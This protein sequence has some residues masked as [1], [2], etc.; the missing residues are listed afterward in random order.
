MR[1]SARHPNPRSYAYDDLYADYH[2]ISSEL[3][4]D[5]PIGPPPRRTGG[6]AKV[7]AVFVLL[8][9]GGTWAAFG[10]P[11][12]WPV[13][14]WADWL[15]SQT[16]TAAPEADPKPP[17]PA[18]PIKPAAAIPGPAPEP[19][20]GAAPAPKELSPPPRTVPLTT[21]ALPPPAVGKA[22]AEPLP[23]PTV[24]PGDPY[25]VRAVAVGLH[26]GLSRVLLARL[27]AADYRNAGIAIKTALAETPDTAVLVWP[28]KRAPDLALFKVRFVPG[29][30][31][32]CRRYVVTITKD[33]WSTTAAPM[34]RCG[35]Q[36]A[37]FRPG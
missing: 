23:P 8:A 18:G 7:W 4:A 15:A 9:S 34:E 33:G 27:S 29:A 32:A 10:D 13:R 20:S 2:Y 25:Q 6:R 12:T 26:P 31:P 28:R 3:S 14:G 36:V 17:L 24:D 11:T 35:S 37:R 30:A 5:E 21:A 19:P 1:A 22:A 16:T